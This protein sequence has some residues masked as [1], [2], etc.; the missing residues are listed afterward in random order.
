MCPVCWTSLAIAVAT[1]TGAGASVR[2]LFPLGFGR[3]ARR[4]VTSVGAREQ[5]EDHECIESLGRDP[6]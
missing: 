4:V 3:S 2:A 6:R 1:T 5:E